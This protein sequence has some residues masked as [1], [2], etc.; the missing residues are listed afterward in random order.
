MLTH[1]HRKGVCSPDPLPELRNQS[2]KVRDWTDPYTCVS[3]RKLTQV[4]LPLPGIWQIWTHEGCV[5]NEVRSLGGRVLRKV[6]T[7]N[8]QMITFLMSTTTQLAH[9]LPYCVSPVP[10]DELI[11]WFP[12]KKRKLYSRELQSLLDY[13]LTK[14]DRCIKAFVKNEKLLIAE[15]DGDPRMIQAR[16]PRFNLMFAQFTRPM[17][18]VLYQL[19]HPT[20][21]YPLIA[22]GLNMRRRA[23]VLRM[24]WENLDNP[25]SLSL[26][27]SRWDMHVSAEMLKIAHH[28]YQH[29]IKDPVFREMLGVQLENHCFT[30]GNVKY[31]VNGSVMSGDM[32]T[33]LGNCVLVV[34]VLLGLQRFLENPTHTDYRQVRALFPDQDYPELRK[35]KTRMLFFDD[36]DDHVIFVERESVDLLN[37]IL[38]RWWS[39]VGHEMKVEGQTDDFNQVLFCQ[40]KP[41]YHH[42]MWEM[43][44]DPRKVLATA[45]VVTGDRVD[46]PRLRAEYQGTVW[47]A[48]ALLHQGQP[49]L[50][51]LF[52]RLRRH[53]RRRIGSQ[54]ARETVMAGIERMAMADN[55]TTVEITDVEP[56]AREQVFRMWGVET[57]LQYI[58][59]N[60]I[61]LRKGAFSSVTSHQHCFKT[62]TEPLRCDPMAQT[63]VGRLSV[64]MA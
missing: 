54:A 34:L 25:V 50:G 37:K 40:H 17:E 55:R 43:M 33:A 27:L 6:D 52:D 15:K 18:K 51:P 24:M 14:R 36:G 57:D 3:K 53:E 59:E 5:H 20:L 63:L 22:K 45:F 48:R 16:T 23:Q 64:Q 2:I 32:T 60:N 1:V 30:Q 26:D 62:V 29:F 38:P 21:H 13:P 46:D 12:Q 42:G 41:L 35:Q 47:E 31:A 7:P 58:L 39:L 56:E 28:F 11:L 8:P 61:Q 10:M 49:I 9:R 44:P 4:Q 19:R